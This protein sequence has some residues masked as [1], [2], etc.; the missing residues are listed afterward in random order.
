MTTVERTELICSM[1]RAEHIR[2]LS[3]L[4]G[5]DPALFDELA[6][7]ARVSVRGGPELDA[8]TEDEYRKEKAR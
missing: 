4:A 8:A 2:I 5:R 7:Q 3:R 1:S 6:E